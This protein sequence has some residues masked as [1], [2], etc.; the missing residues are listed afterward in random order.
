L[1]GQLIKYNKGERSY[2]FLNSSN[3]KDFDEL[4]ELFFEVLAVKTSERTKSV[5]EKFGNIPYLNSSLFERNDLENQTIRINS[6]KDRLEL[7]LYKSTILKDS[8]GKRICGKKLT[9]HYL[10]DFLDA[11]DFASESSAK[12]QEQNKSI[13]NA[14]VLGLIFEK[15]NGYKDGSFFTPGFITMYMSRETIRKSVIQK[16]NE[17]F[18]WNIKEFS[19]LKDKIDCTDKSVRLKSNEIINSLKICDPAVGSGH[20]LVS[21]LNELITI[22]SDLGILQMNDG[23]RIR[24]YK[25]SIENDELIIIDEETDRIFEYSLN[26]NKKPV[27]ELQTLQEALFHEKQNIIENCLF[28]VDINPKSV[29]ICRLRLWIELLKNSYYTKESNYVELET[30]PNIDINIKCGNSLISRFS[31][32]ADLSKALKSIKYDIKAYRG[33]VNDY[34]NAHDKQEKKGLEKII[35]S[36]KSDFRSEIYNNDPKV[37]RLNKLGGELYSLLNQKQIFELSAKEK[38]NRKQQQEKLELEI[39][40]LTAQIEEIKSS[41]IYRNAF[42]WR[43]EFPEVLDEKGDFVGFD[44]VIGNPPYLSSKDF[45]K[46]LINYLNINYITSQYQLDL[47]ISFIEKA[48]NLVTKQYYISF[49]TPNSWLKNL[50]FSNCRDYLLKTVSFK[51]IFP[52]LANVFI[53]ASVDTL[54]FIA[55]KTVSDSIIKISK[56]NN[57]NPIIDHLVDQKRFEK[58]DKYIFDV[59]TNN[60]FYSIIQKVRQ[61]SNILQDVAEITRGVNPYDKYRGQDEEIIKNKAYHSST[62][63]DQTF[64]PEIR[65]KH[66]NCYSYSWDGKHYISYGDWLAAPREK[67]FFQGPRIIMRQVLGEKLNCTIINEDFIIDQSIFIAKP[68]KDNE[69]F[70]DGIQGVLASKLIS[71][72]FKYTSNEFDLLFPKIKIGEFKNLPIPKE[73][74]KVQVKIGEKVQEIIKLK[75]SN[76]NLNTSALEK[77]IDQLVYKIYDLTDEEIAIIENSEIKKLIK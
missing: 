53:E 3:I 36:I 8:E 32:D 71:E 72:F 61:K 34:K 38:T 33:F 5:N 29:M 66:V 31:L 18:G 77:Q 14:S 45:N 55:K 27:T 51:T 19:E 21:A 23:A 48:I 20:F 15:I 43:F 39:N 1:E 50:M 40:K 65:G 52:N 46:N 76:P 25:I 6:L 2:A 57:Q 73:L 11:Y 13:I 54:I 68:Y 24:G 9:L 59:E 7:P 10:F 17:K 37:I 30:L 75:V 63:K 49:I 22:K 44:V 28:G 74:D 41:A 70:I 56:F 12:I 4:N 26:Q 67:K 16:F 69:K 62:K 64:V 60:E 42:E 58:N 47:Y 35:D